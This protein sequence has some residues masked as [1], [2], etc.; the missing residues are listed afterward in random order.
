MV[1]QNNEEWS[2]LIC[3]GILATFGVVIISLKIRQRGDAYVDE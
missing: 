3:N 1:H 2:L